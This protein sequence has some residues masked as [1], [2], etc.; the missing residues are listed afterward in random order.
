[1]SVISMDNKAIILFKRLYLI[2]FMWE[3]SKSGCTQQSPSKKQDWKYEKQKTFRQYPRSP[4]YRGKR[5]I[6]KY[7]DSSTDLV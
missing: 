2:D 4:K 3:I 7:Y 5:S 1:M 6:T